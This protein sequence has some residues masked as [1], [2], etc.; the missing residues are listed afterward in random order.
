ML[1]GANIFPLTSQDKSRDRFSGNRKVCL[2]FPVTDETGM[3][4]L[5]LWSMAA[6]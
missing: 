5:R 1:Q 3:K 6:G 2:C 4:T